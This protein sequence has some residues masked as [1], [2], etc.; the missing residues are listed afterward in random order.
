L[1]RGAGYVQRFFEFPDALPADAAESAAVIN[2]A[3]ERLILQCP[4]QYLW[5]YNRYKVPR[6]AVDQTQKE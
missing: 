3:M 4:Q 1:P 6:A 2:R 5:A